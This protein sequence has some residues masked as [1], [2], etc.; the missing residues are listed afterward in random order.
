MRK[1]ILVVAA[2]VFATAI[3]SAVAKTSTV[4]IT[5]N[6]YVPKS[7]TIAQSDTVKF[8]NSDTV[9]HQVKFKSTTN[10]TCVPSPLV[11]QP[12]A[13]GSCTFKKTGTFAYTDPNKKVSTFRGTIIVTAAPESISL[14]VKPRLLIYGGKVT[15]SGILSTQKAGANADVL[16]QQCG[17]STAT[18]VGTVKTTTGGAYTSTAQPL[19][20]TAYTT[21]VGTVK[22]SAVTVRVRPRLR[23]AR[24]AAHRYSVRVFAA[25]SFAGK[26]VNFQRYNS[27]LLRWVAVKRVSLRANSTGVAPTVV[28]AAKWRS[29]IKAGRRVRV[30]LPQTPGNCYAAGSSNTIRS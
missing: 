30:T 9:A 17:V 10:V 1:I 4:S 8:T 19:K 20:N 23:L 16:A 29:A 2:L 22:S 13:S 21:N 6:G 27:T 3:G 14:T 24:I 18:K 25:Q 28:T 26:Y 7:L 15:L 11:L 5:K 12:G